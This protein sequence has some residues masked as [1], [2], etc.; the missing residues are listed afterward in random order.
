[1]S[2]YSCGICSFYLPM[3][4]RGWGR[5]K[6]STHPKYGGQIAVRIDNGCGAFR[7]FKME[8][9]SILDIKDDYDFE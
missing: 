4:A 5:C 2:D 8:I 1:M 9:L 6:I 7:P 3:T